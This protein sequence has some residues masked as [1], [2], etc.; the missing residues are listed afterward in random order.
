[1][2]IRNGTLITTGTTQSGMYVTDLDG[3][4][5][6][7]NSVFLFT[8][9]NPGGVRIGDR[10][11]TIAGN[12]AEFIA[13]SQLNFPSFENGRVDRYRSSRARPF[14]PATRCSPSGPAST[15]CPSRTC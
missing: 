7:Y 2:T 5:D 4:A 12:A 8:F 14:R 11:C 9:S 3:P 15:P 6:G 10:L 1:M 13:N